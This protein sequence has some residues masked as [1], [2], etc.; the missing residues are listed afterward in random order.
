LLLAGSMV[1]FTSIAHAVTVTESFTGATTGP[2]WTL[3][4]SASLTGTGAPDPIGSG[5]LRLTPVSGG[6]GYAYFSQVLPITER[7]TV[8]FEFADWGGSGADGLT[9]FLFDAGGGFTTGGGGGTF[10]YET[11]PTGALAVG[12]ADGFASSFTNS[13]ANAIAVR[14]PGPGTAFI[15]GTGGLSPTPQTAAR[16]LTPADPNYRRVTITLNP[17]GAGAMAV[18]VQLQTGA[19]ISNVL[20]N[21]V[22]SG[23]PANVRFGLSAATGGL[24]N[25]HE[26]RN[27]ALATGNAVAAIPTLSEWSLVILATMLLLG[28]MVV[29]SR[30]R[31]ETS[32]G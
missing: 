20:A 26:V 16:G 8:S 12:I 32:A 10:G 28:S 1:G 18:S 21:V 19:T 22:V 25:N 24:T 4:G 11:M 3:S 27:Y 30:R 17:A 23:L 13:T 15:G 6:V 9:F 5:W 2:G 29:L 14:G 31:R 7:I